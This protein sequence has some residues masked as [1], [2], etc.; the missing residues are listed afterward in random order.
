MRSHGRNGGY[1]IEISTHQSRMP[2]SCK[3]SC[4]HEP[5]LFHHKNQVFQ[6]SLLLV[7]GLIYGRIYGLKFRTCWLP[8]KYRGVIRCPDFSNE[9][10]ERPRKNPT[11]LH[12]DKCPSR[13]NC[14]LC[15]RHMS[16]QDCPA[17]LFP[18]LVAELVHVGAQRTPIYN[19]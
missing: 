6:E 9:F 10:W 16:L 12:L 4:H 2:I 8:A 11:G 18:R 1:S 17:K 15:G 3:L 14:S 5:P 13:T 7:R 19:C